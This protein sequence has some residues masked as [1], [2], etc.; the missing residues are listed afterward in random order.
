MKTSIVSLLF[1]VVCSV[2]ADYAE[3]LARY[4]DDNGMVDYAGLLMDRKPLD[5][6]IQSL[7]NPSTADWSE[8]DWIAFWINAYNAR[9][10]QVIL[11]HYPVE[12]IRRIRG[13]WTKLSAPIL[14]EDRTLDEIEHKILRKKFN[15]PRIHMALVCAARSCPRLRNEPY[16]ADRLDEQLA[17]QSRDFLLRPDR[18]RVEGKYARISPIFKWFKRDFDSVPAF[19]KQYSGQDISGL[20]IKYQFYDWSLNEQENSK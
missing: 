5:D 20:K 15:E 17:D 10:L 2:R 16:K 6:Y 9:T 19:I 18:F 4:V 14:G 12:G 13:A 8:A 11:D 3:V 1:A 7:E